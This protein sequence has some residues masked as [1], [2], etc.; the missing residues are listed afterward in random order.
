M[1]AGTHSEHSNT[2]VVSDTNEISD[3][4]RC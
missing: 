4:A 2:R 1:S 3:S